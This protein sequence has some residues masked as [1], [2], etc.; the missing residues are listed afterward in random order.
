MITELTESDEYYMWEAL[1]TDGITIDE[2]GLVSFTKSGTYHVRI[3]N[4]DGVPLSDWYEITAVD[5]VSSE[6]PA[7]AGFT[8]HYVLSSDTTAQ[9][10]AP[11]A[12]PAPAATEAPASTSSDTS[13]EKPAEK[14]YT[15]PEVKLTANDGSISLKWEPVKDAEKYRVYKYVNGKLR[16]LTETDKRAVRI[17]GTK[18]GKEYTFAVKALVNG[19]WTKVY[20]K[21]LVSIT[22]K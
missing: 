11:A 5:P 15:K 21:D 6:P 17:T 8:P 22:A 16:L 13:A 19:K 12:S 2:I 7:Y 10:P 3:V 1:E 18:A 4:E 14:V 20:T 9:T